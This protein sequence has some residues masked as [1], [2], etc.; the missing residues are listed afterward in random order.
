MAKRTIELVDDSG[1]A[2]DLTLLGS[3]A[4]LRELDSINN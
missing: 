3:N 1:T 4:E 2:V